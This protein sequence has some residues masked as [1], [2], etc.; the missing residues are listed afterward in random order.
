M[1]GPTLRAEEQLLAEIESRLADDRRPYPPTEEALT[2]LIRECRALQKLSRTLARRNTRPE[3]PLDP[4]ASA[5][6]HRFVGL[7][8]PPL[9]T[10]GDLANWLGLSV[11]ELDWLADTRNRLSRPEARARPHY[12]VHWVP[13]RQGPPRPVEAPLPRLKAAQREILRGILN[14][15]PVHPAAFG[16]V[17][18]RGAITGAARHAGE[19]MVLTADLRDF[20]PSIPAR[21]VHAIF[22]CL[23]YPGRVARLL[24]G[25]VTT[26]TP[27]TAMGPIE[28]A[29]P[30]LHEARQRLAVPHLPQGAPTSPALANLAAHG[31]DRR[32]TALAESRGARY[33]RYAD[34]LAFSGPR[35]GFGREA[36]AFLARL[37]EI[38]ADEGFAL[39]TRKLRQMPAGQ[40]QQVTGIIVNQ[41]VGLAREEIDR[42][43]ATLHNCLRDGPSGQNREDH[44]AF[45]A[46]LEGRV[47]WMAQVLPHR[48]RRLAAMLDAID[49]SL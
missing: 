20:F 16:F 24:T 35:A 42:L 25:L 36:T 14:P 31:L 7:D 10:G 23:G 9:C 46:H 32:L 47:A 4:P 1:A 18:G 6:A 12:A 44:P 5:P 30:A 49:W 11:I 22:R 2:A 3:I 8:I 41:R 33:T 34:D 26:A 43:K 17:A 29:G 48:G 37:G 38:A 39:N 28:G 45:R 19:E 21:R 13:R 15:V 40:R 27:R